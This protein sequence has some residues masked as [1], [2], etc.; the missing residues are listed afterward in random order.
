MGVAGAL[1]F[2]SPSWAPR[3]F[4]LGQEEVER[5]GLA[6]SKWKL[7][8]SDEASL[9]RFLGFATAPGKSDFD[10]WGRMVGIVAV[11]IGRDD[12]TVLKD[13]LKNQV[14]AHLD[15]A[16]SRWLYQYREH[17]KLAGRGLSSDK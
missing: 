8:S 7:G 1:V 6:S 15:N 2:K 13:Q 3:L 11:L 16:L 12:V 17:H 14:E 5:R 9:N 4:A 10:S